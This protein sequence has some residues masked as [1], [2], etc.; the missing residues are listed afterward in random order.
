MNGLNTFLMVFHE[1]WNEEVSGNRGKV[2]SCFSEDDKR[3]FLLG[4]DGVISKVAEELN[5]D[6]PVRMI[7]DYHSFDAVFTSRYSYHIE[8][9]TYPRDVK[10]VIKCSRDDDIV[11]AAWALIHWRSP[12]KV[13]I[14]NDWIGSGDSWVNA[15]LSSIYTMIDCEDEFNVESEVTEYLFLV[16]I[17]GD[18]D[19]FSKWYWSSNCQ[20]NLRILTADGALDRAREIAAKEG[21]SGVN[22]PQRFEYSFELNQPYEDAISLHGALHRKINRIVDSINQQCKQSELAVTKGCIRISNTE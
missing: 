17:R 3:Q 1:V 18:S 21:E 13:L 9:E 12:L 8:D 20:R 22:L 15:K 6:S 7:C 5:N 2:I 11:N 14:F 10:V 19:E 16:A 4:G